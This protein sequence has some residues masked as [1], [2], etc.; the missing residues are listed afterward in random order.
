MMT[1]NVLSNLWLS[2]LVGPE[3]RERREG[4]IIYIVSIGG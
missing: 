4:S 1:N 2:K 3:M